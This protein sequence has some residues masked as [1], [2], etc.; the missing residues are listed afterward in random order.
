MKQNRQDNRLLVF[1]VSLDT[2]YPLPKNLLNNI[3]SYT[4][5]LY[6]KKKLLKVLIDWD[7]KEELTNSSV[8]QY[9]KNY[10]SKLDP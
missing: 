1:I 8:I 10:E 5:I 9:T 2:N 7:I 3:N 4:T 6:K